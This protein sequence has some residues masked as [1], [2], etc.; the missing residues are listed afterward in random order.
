[1]MAP[2]PLLNVG[3]VGATGMVGKEFL[4]ILE[5]RKFPVQEL[6]LFA[7]AKSEGSNVNFR[8]RPH[9]VSTLA[10]GCF[11]GLHIVFF[12]AGAPISK[13]WAPKAVKEGALAV[14]N[15]SA[16]RMVNDVP[17]VVPE[18]NGHLLPV[19]GKPALIANPN[20]STIQLA[21]VLNPLKEK[22]GLREVRVASYQSVSGAGKEAVEELKQQSIDVLT[23]NVSP[24][25]LKATVLP[26]P[27]A[28]NNIPQIGDFDEHGY[29]EE[30]TKIINETRK[31]L[32]LHDLRVTAFAVRTP[33]LNAH[34]EAVWVTLKEAATRE[35][36]LKTLRPAPGVEVIDDPQSQ[37][38][39]LNIVAS[40]RD[41]VY[42]GRIRQDPVDPKTWLF[43][44]AAD[45]I[46]KG[47][48]LNGIQIAEQVFD[49]NR[50]P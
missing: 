8:G 46:R 9:T 21:I 43:W 29:S 7:G 47:A 34:S 24:T 49:L 25:D 48:A 6:R 27:I 41:P 17:L 10:N 50:T 40:G 5:E 13:E 23:K 4:K 2:N 31:I 15:S 45:N 20:C 38:Y 12:S 22:F 26:H 32:D 39:P 28:F 36:I 14:D 16:Y 42:V 30:E 3:V 11:K 44:I 37:K 1:M 35:T 33:T 19:A 18:V